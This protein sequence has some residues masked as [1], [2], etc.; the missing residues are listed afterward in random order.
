M[1]WMYEKY[2][3][4]AELNQ[5]EEMYRQERA[6]IACGMKCLPPQY[7][8]RPASKHRFVPICGFKQHPNESQE[9]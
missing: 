8:M 5:V 9:L 4:N 7:P 1:N 6:S 2:L 3:R